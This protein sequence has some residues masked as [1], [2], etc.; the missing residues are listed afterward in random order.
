MVAVKW[1]QPG[2]KTWEAGVEKGVLYLP[3]G[4]GAYNTGFAWN[5]LT[6]VNES[7]SGAEANKT[8][9][10]N[11]VYANIQSA[12][13]FSGAIEALTH[14][15]Q[16]SLCDGT[17]EPKPGVYA[18]QQLRRQFGLCYRSELGND[19]LGVGYGYKLHLVYNALASPSEKSRSTINE[20]TEPMPL[21]WDFTTTPMSVDALARPTAKLTIVSTEVAPADLAALE[22]LLYGSAGAEPELPTPDDVLALFVT[23]VG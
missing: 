2:E 19:L 10:D 22:L 16:F 8:Y 9:A 7:P 5:G 17:A 11:R 4:T 21:S 14:P 13:E 18:G 12:E 6:A 3:D 15:R 1:D 23:P 20:T